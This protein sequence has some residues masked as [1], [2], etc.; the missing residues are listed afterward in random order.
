MTDEQ[1]ANH[2]KETTC[3]ECKLK[4]YNGVKECKINPLTKVKHH[5]HITG[6]FFQRFVMDVI[7]NYNIK[8]LYR[9]I[10][11]NLKGMIPIY[12]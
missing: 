3:Q 5:D 6:D 11:M 8:S 4:F 7:F 1:I 2:N 12:L 9:F 10:N